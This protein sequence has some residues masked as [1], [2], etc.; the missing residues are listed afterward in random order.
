MTR[1]C[2]ALV[3]LLA[4]A[5]VSCD[6]GSASDVSSQE[7]KGALIPENPTGNTILYVSNQSHAVSPVDIRILLDGR[8]II[9]SHF[10]VGDQ[11]NYVKYHFD[12]PEGKHLL[13][14]V[15]D[16]GEAS[17][18]KEIEIAA[19]RWGFVGYW[20]VPDDGEGKR[21]TVLFQDEPIYFR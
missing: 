4:L 19:K 10:T 3:V 5:I 9:A 2:A 14:A 18:E 20:Y 7:T 13:K 15:S 17:I 1:V 21:F 12:L 6:G 11:H 16:A 8:P